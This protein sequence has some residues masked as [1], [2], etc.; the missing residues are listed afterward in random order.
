VDLNSRH[1]ETKHNPE[2]KKYY[3]FYSSVCLPIVGLAFAIG[4]TGIM[5][6]GW[7]A[8]IYQ[9][10]TKPSMAIDVR[11]NLFPTIAFLGMT[12]FIAFRFINSFPTIWA[13]R[14]GL[15]ISYNIFHRAFIAWEDIVEVKTPF[16]RGYGT[17]VSAKRITSFHYLTSDFNNLPGFW[18]SPY[19]KSRTE[20]I[21]IIRIRAT[22]L[23][24]FEP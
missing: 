2:W 15:I 24:R 14:D 5:V 23:R 21:E 7:F 3:S 22:N 10:L 18:I 4:F 8:T 11:G 17:L 12:W 9:S 20:L 13:G 19:I 1:I 6:I 16:V